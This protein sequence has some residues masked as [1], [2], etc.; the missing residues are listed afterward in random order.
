MA[1]RQG[2]IIR[3]N[4]LGRIFEKQDNDKWYSPGIAT[5]YCSADFWGNDIEV[6]WEP[7]FKVGDVVEGK[8]Q[9][10]SLPPRT[11]IVYNGMPRYPAPMEKLFNGNWKGTGSVGELESSSLVGAREVV[12]LP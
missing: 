7:P 12:W 1:L 10:D 9:L 5:I 2:T 4:L 6:L 8:Q 11:V 3:R